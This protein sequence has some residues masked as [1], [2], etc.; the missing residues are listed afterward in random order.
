[1]SNFNG[2]E[3]V[4]E[5]KVHRAIHGSVVA[6]GM[7]KGGVGKDASDDQILAKYDSLGGLIEKDGNKVKTG[8]FWDFK[9]Q[10]PKKDPE[11]IFLFRALDGDLVEVPEGKK[12][13]MEVEAAKLHAEAEKK[14]KK[15]KSS[16][17]K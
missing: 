17:K 12:L 10:A 3:C 9:K 7:A 8:S 13:P 2:Y 14:P 4:N 16:K 15:K 5:S 11:V 1:M 6:G